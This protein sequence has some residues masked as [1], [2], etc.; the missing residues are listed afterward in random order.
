MKYYI[1]NATPLSEPKPPNKTKY[2]LSLDSA[3][4]NAGV[5]CYDKYWRNNHKQPPLY[6][7]SFV[8]DEKLRM[9]GMVVLSLEYTSKQFGGTSYFW[10]KKWERNAPIYPMNKHTGEIGRIEK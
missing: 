3:R 5:E 1:S 2:F 4:K 8:Y 10:L 9:I 6:V 7:Y